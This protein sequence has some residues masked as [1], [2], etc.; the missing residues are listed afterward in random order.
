MQAPAKQFRL[1]WRP[2]LFSNRW[3]CWVCTLNFVRYRLCFNKIAEI[4]RRIITTSYA[5]IIVFSVQSIF[6]TLY[7]ALKMQKKKKIVQ[8]FFPPLS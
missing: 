5:I 1:K 4:W 8:I 6:T 7:H 3:L 2:N